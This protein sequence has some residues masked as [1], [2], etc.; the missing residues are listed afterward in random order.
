ELG[1]NFANCM[2]E[3]CFHCG[4]NIESDDVFFDQKHFCC[5][6]C[7]T[8]YEILNSKGLENFYA[9]NS[10]AG[11]RP[12]DKANLHFDFLDSPVIFDEIIDI[13]D[14]WTTVVTS[15]I[16]AIHCTSCVW[17]LE[18]LH[19]IDPRINY[20]NVQFTQRKIQ[21]AYQSDKLKLSE[22]AKLLTKLGYKPS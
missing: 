6:G 17:L 4:Q 15:Q 14:G 16:P 3:S 11:I 18:S 5:V 13:S 8:V 10:D 9:M 20:S 21:I 12:D 1:S 19:D 7:K 22:L 2:A